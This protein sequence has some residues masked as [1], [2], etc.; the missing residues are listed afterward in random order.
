MAGSDGQKISFSPRTHKNLSVYTSVAAELAV[1]DKVMVTRNDKT[2]D[3]ANGDRFTV[4]GTTEK[5]T[6]TLTNAKGREIELDQKQA[7][8][9][10]YAYATTVHK[11][12]G[13]TCDRVLFN[14]DTR[15]LTTSKDVFTLGFP[16]PVMKSRSSPMTKSVC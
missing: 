10:S 13:L 16:A 12:Q 8:Y 6:F 4:T 5:G 9:L 15:S 7:A 3:V 14:I 11:A 2:L 1:G